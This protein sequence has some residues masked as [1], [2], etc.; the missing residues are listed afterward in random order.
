MSRD[1]IK[2]LWKNEAG[3]I[4]IYFALAVIPILGFIGLSVDM[5]RAYHSR[6][7]V[8]N[9]A[10][11]AALAAAKVPPENADAEARRVFDAYI[12][13]SS[14]DG[15]AKV[16]SVQVNE[17]KGFVQVKAETD[18]DM[19]FIKVL[20]Y[21]KL[22]VRGQSRVLIANNTIE[23]AVVLD[24][25]GSMN[26]YISGKRRID[27]LK[28]ATKL[29]I[30]TIYPDSKAPDD[31]FMAIIPY[32]TQ[33][34]VGPKK[35]WLNAQGKAMVQDKDFFPKEKAG[36][37]QGCLEARLHDDLHKSDTPPTDENTRFLPYWWPSTRIN[38]YPYP[39]GKVRPWGKKSNGD[40]DWRP[41][42]L[43]EWTS[44]SPKNPN[45]G[46]PVEVLPLTNEKDKLLAKNKDMFPI[47]RGGTHIFSGLKV[48]WWT[49]SP[50]WRD[51]WDGG[52]KQNELP[53]DY[54]DSKKVLI[55]MT[56]GYNQW[57]GSDAPQSKYGDKHY[58][59][60]GRWYGNKHSAL[61]QDVVAPNTMNQYTLELCNIVK[62]QGIQIYTVT[63][64]VAN[65][66]SQNLMKSCASNPSAY[67]DAQSASEL[68]SAFSEIAKKIQE[69][70]YAWPG[71]DP[72]E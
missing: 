32:I 17:K 54:Q 31:I 23:V 55:L 47:A 25:T 5:S 72:I 41:K 50:K 46:C 26:G 15:R 28:D 2:K 34:N 64:G 39:G 63:F 29:L 37:W 51:M 53:K 66:A 14:L 56:D 60:Y 4:F 62:N 19:S 70:R 10:D 49:I 16:E 43:T 18:V 57:I 27:H 38:E 8:V 67:Y 48:G 71:A 45:A 9:A 1:C 33:V 24:N 59:A 35:E 21:D 68:T 61:N 58:T 44:T 52:S 22:A 40:N 36:E 6:A 13:G 42:K 65:T 69:M 11:A 30:E 7:M 3:G 12:K 20:G